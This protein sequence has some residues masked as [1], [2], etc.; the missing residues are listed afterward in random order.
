MR[1]SWRISGRRVGLGSAWHSRPVVRPGNARQ[2]VT[3]VQH[4]RFEA[5]RPIYDDQADLAEPHEIIGISL[6]NM[7]EIG[8]QKTET[9]ME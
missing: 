6:A 1:Q 4:E 5:D 9:I 8:R 2:T 3:K 7:A